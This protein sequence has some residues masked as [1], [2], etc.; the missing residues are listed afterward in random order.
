MRVEQSGGIYCRDQH[1]F[2]RPQES[3][4]TK[5]LGIPEGFGLLGLRLF[6]VYDPGSGAGASCK[7]D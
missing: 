3:Q 6:G 2:Q 4:Q 7:R 5:R 1:P